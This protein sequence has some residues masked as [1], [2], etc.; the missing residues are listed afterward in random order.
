[1]AL[2]GA[3]FGCFS[4]PNNRTMLGSAP[5]A[6]AGGAGGM[7]ATA[8]LLGTTLGTTVVGLCFQ[9]AGAEA[10]RGSRSGGDRLRAGGGGAEPGAAADVGKKGGRWLPTGPKW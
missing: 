2:C 4:T 9:L 8:R 10:G 1:M 7:Q 3:G 6:R 5:K